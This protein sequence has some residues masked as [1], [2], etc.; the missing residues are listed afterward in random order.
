MGN[1]S[2]VERH[3]LDVDVGGSIPPSPAMKDLPNRIAVEDTDTVLKELRLSGADVSFRKDEK[4]LVIRYGRRL[5][6][7]KIE[8]GDWVYNSA[9]TLGRI[10]GNAFYDSLHGPSFAHRIFPREKK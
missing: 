8:G 10:I 6:G 3:T 1:S 2:A 9:V 5:R 4:E 7:Y